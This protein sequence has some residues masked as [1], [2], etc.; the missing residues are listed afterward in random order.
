M[1]PFE[2]EN[3]LLRTPSCLDQAAFASAVASPSAIAFAKRSGGNVESKESATFG[4]IPLTFCNCKNMRFEASE[5]NPYNVIA[6]CETFNDVYTFTVCPACM[7]AKSAEGIRV[8]YPTP[9]DLNNRR[10]GVNEID[11]TMQHAYHAVTSRIQL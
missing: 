1:D 5:E 11:L 3:N 2:F 4:P 6:S 8:S 10:S 7:D 9:P